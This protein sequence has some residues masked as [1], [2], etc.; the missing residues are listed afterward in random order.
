MKSWSIKQRSWKFGMILMALLFLFAAGE[1]ISWGQ[2]IFNIESNAFFV[3]NNL[4]KETNLHN[5]TIGNISLNKLVFS[6]IIFGTLL[7]YI[8]ILPVVYLLFHR[9]QKLMDDFAIPIMEAHHVLAFIISTVIIV[10]IPAERKWELYEFCFAF[11]FLMIFYNPF[12]SW[13]YKDEIS[14]VL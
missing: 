1:E 5:L 10:I 14:S 6:K 12:N 9:A 3:E 8:L 7:I 4:Q 13:I 11:I 2:R